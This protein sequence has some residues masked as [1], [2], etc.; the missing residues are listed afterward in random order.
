M[1]TQRALTSGFEGDN[2]DQGASPQAPQV[3][4]D[5]MSNE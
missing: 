3:P 1:I 5:L 4:V 2:V